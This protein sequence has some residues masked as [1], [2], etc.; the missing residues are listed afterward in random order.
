M[1]KLLLLA[2]ATCFLF[3]VASAQ[4]TLH[5]GTFDGSVLAVT[6]DSDIEIPAWYTDTEAAPGDPIG[7]VHIPLASDDTKISSRDGGFFSYP[8][9]DWDDKSFLAPDADQPVVGYTSQSILGFYDLG[10]DPNP[11]LYGNP[12]LMIAT[13]EMHTINDAGLIG[14]TYTVFQEGFN[15][16]N[17][18]TLFGNIDGTTS[19]IPDLVFAD[20]FFSPNND[21]VWTVYPTSPVTGIPGIEVCFALAGTDA[22]AIDDLHIVQTG[23]P[24]TYTEDVGGPGGATSGEWCGTLA[25]GSY[26]LDFELR[27][28]AG[29]VIPLSI[30]LEIAYDPLCDGSVLSIPC[31]SAFP[32]TDVYVPVNLENTCLVGGY[33]ILVSWDPTTLDLIE[34]TPSYRSDYGDE[35]FNVR[36]D[37]GCEQCPVGGSARIVW[38]ADINNGV[39][40]DPMPSGTG[41][42]FWMHFMVEYDLPWGMVIPIEFVVEHYSDNTISDETGYILA[43]PTLENGCVNITDPNTFKG[44]PNMNGYYYEI[45]DA[46]LVARR[47]IEGYIVWSENGTS[48]DAIQEAAADLNNNG[49]VDVA[50][51]VRFINII[52]GNINPPK[53]DPT[54]EVASFSMPNVVGDEMTVSVR[55]A[56]DLGGALISIDHTGIELGEPVANGMEVLSHDADGVLNLVVFSLEGNTVAAG[57]ANLVTIPVLSNNGGTMDFAEVSA[58]D[59]YGRLLEANASLVAPLPEAFAVKG[60]Y[61]NPFN[62]KTLINF[63][64]PVNSDVS[65]NIYSITGQLVETISGQFEAGSQSVSWDASDV[66]SGVYFY[67]VSAGDFSQTMKMTLLK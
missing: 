64:L 16:A 18:A 1:K 39:P 46:V 23:G 42:I 30:D 38:I 37:D 66:A 35:Y 17:G 41:P 56:L 26:T 58:A 8:L 49:F 2:L 43:W 4:K 59:S 63:D 13:Y 36:L 48:D 47:L 28:N 31:P 7:F 29:A 60:N 50:D 12:Q 22:D 24:G 67:K 55:S 54:S 57:K 27:D 5:Y 52:N 45:A 61:P 19:Y 65:I 3:S 9:T 21:P 10:G 62:A 40:N 53:L 33:E 20:L 11:P 6:I 15:S 32:G 25:A 51:L 34:I 14:N 44:D